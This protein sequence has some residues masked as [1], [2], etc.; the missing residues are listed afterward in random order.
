MELPGEMKSVFLGKPRETVN[1][2]IDAWV[3]DP[4]L[5]YLLYLLLVGNGSGH[6]PVGVWIHAVG[7]TQLCPLLT[8]LPTTC[9]A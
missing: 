2:V 9:V 3:E 6:N 1:K 4:P 8:H 7:P 5:R